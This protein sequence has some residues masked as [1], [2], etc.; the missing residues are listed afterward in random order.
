MPERGIYRGAVPRG[1]AIPTN[2]PFYINSTDNLPH[3]IPAG[4]GSTEQ[5]I[6]LAISTSGARIAAGSANFVS[7]VAAVNTGLTTVLAF[8]AELSATGYATGATEIT[9]AVVSGAITPTGGATVV[10]VQGYRLA[11]TTASASGTGLFYWTAV[12]M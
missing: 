5:I 2:A 4:T 1:Y 3:V 11:T 7:G 9:D 6:P 8:Q 10:N 12:G